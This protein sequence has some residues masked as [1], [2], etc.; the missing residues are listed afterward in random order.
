MW[1]RKKNPVSSVQIYTL[2]KNCKLTETEIN[3]FCS[4]YGHLE[5]RYSDEFHDRFLIL[6]KRSIKD[7]GQKAF[8]ISINEDEKS[9]NALLDRLNLQ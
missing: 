5:I 2:K 1:T 9:L 3:A 4:Q 8:E 7:A 6:D